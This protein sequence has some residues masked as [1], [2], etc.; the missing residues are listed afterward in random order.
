MRIWGYE[1]F[2]KYRK[3]ETLQS[4]P[5]ITQNNPQGPMTTL[6][7][8]YVFRKV[9]GDFYEA[10][11][12]GIPIIDTAITRLISMNGTLKIIGDNPELV[13]AL[14]DF[15]LN[16][17]V[18]D[19]Q[20]GMQAFLQNF[21][22]ETFEQGFSVSE[23]VVTPDLKDVAG[24][25]VA[26]SKNIVYRRNAEGRAE[27]W[28]R[29]PGSQVTRYATV[30]GDL[31]NSIMNASYGQRLAVC[32]SEERKLNPANLLYHSIN[33]ENSDPYG[34]SMMRSLE[35]VSQILATLQTSI[36]NVAERFGDPSYHVHYKAAK[37]G[38]NPDL[39]IRRTALQT[40]FNA[41][42]NAK[43][44]GKSADLVTA[45]SLDSE[46]NVKVIG[47]DGQILTYDTPL[48]HV[49]EQIVA[50]TNL[51]AWM[52][53]IYWST[54]ERMATLE[55]EAAL[56]DAKVRQL[57]MLPELI[58]LFSIVLRLRGYKWKT[59]TTDPTKPGDWGIMFETPNLRD[60][61]AQAQARFLNAQADMMGTVGAAG[62]SQTQI[63]LTGA[64]AEAAA[65]KGSSAEGGSVE[66]NG[67]RFPLALI[68]Q[69]GRAE[70][71]KATAC[72]C[73]PQ[74]KELRRTIDWPALDA[75]E[76]RFE[77]ELKYDWNELKERVL[78]IVGLRQTEAGKGMK[79]PNDRFSLSDAERQAIMKELETYL[80]YYD[81]RAADSAVRQY[82]GQAYSLG[83][84]QAAYLLGERQPL[85]NLLKNSEVY[86][87]LCKQGF[88]LVKN[89]A[90]AAIHD[91]IIAAMERHTL[92]GSNP[93]DVARDLERQ[94]GDQNSDWERLARS[95]MSM[96]A[97]T[98]K[99][100]EWKEWGVK[101]VEFLPAPDACPICMSLAGDY[102]IA[103]CPVAVRDTH[104]RC[105]CSTRPAASE[106]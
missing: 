6:F 22:G 101:M 37:S 89:S 26:D 105:R 93:L 90:T 4:R 8:D 15:C 2:R 43:R 21:G 80:G 41:V 42:I 54:T 14:E 64:S 31:V 78:T 65:R 92:A 96:A 46:I 104:P 27:P 72:G 48:R 18:N 9:S 56:Q 87:A 29:Y 32:G 34:V 35:F 16:V 63:Q 98:A 88:G 28:Y 10:L 40:D 23:F 1:L 74:K 76:V 49:L 83:L 69:R 11:R 44:Q 38:S 94:F 20:K 79:G 47:H 85:L 73:E 60:V 24:L 58:R 30:P 82:Y 106:A 81:F 66:I 51:P 70:A 36:K 7:R 33:N 84:L 19:T 77:A 62:G 95:E 102:P 39:E 68:E 53:G 67:M 100:D 86:D 50:K 45:G 55:V 71:R 97:E 99:L 61:V 17:A 103:S 52:L 12:E 13:A 59:I 91:E 75:V 3:G 5:Q 57:A 25:R